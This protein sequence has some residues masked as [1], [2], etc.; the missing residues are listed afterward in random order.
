MMGGTSGT[1][2]SHPS[3][4]PEVT[5]GLLNLFLCSILAIIVCLSVIFY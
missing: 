3:G 2:T 1:E 4:A 5:S